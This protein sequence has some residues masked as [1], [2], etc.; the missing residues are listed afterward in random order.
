MLH[1]VLDCLSKVVIK[2][3]G[4]VD[5]YIGDCIMAFWG[6]PVHTPED[7]T[8]ACKTAIECIKKLE[9]INKELIANGIQGIKIRIGIHTGDAIVGNIG[10]ERLFNYTVIGDT[11]NIA[12]RLES[13]NKY[14]KTS[15]IVSEDTISKTGDNFIA[16]QLGLITVKGK[17][18]PIRIF[19]LIGKKNTISDKQEILLQKYNEGFRLYSEKKWS[20]AREL[21]SSILKEFP[22]DGPSKFYMKKCEDFISGLEL[23]KD[24]YIVKMEEK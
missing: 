4:I 3:Y 1:R 20:E 22:E 18:K 6:A 2:H 9:E 24:W 11:V 23:T 14:F 17:T 13:V 8:N 12:S 10:S 15:I 7:E 16:R 5:K 21:F 19:E